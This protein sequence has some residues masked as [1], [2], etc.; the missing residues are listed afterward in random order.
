[1]DPAHPSP[2]IAGALSAPQRAFLDAPLFATVATTDANGAPRQAVIWYRLEDDGRITLNSRLTRFW[3]A[4]LQRD[5][6]LS[7]A[8]IGPDGYSWLGLTGRVAEVDDDPERALADIVA[9]AW[10][11]HPDGPDPADLASYAAYPRITFRVAID[12]VHDHLED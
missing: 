8:V 2:A 5:G 6:R 9:L 4:N 1:M 11:Y 12:G 7:L 3:P 10:R